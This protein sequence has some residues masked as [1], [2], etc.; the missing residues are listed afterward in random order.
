MTYLSADSR[1]H[2]SSYPGTIARSDST[3]RRAVKSEVR[4]R[5]IH[6]QR[7]RGEMGRRSAKQECRGRVDTYTDFRS[8]NVIRT[9]TP[10]R[11]NSVSHR[12]QHKMLNA[13]MT[14]H[15]LCLLQTPPTYL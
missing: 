11:R 12:T 6:G 9:S 4:R 2:L 5:G 15:E 1:R 7:G 10:V 3:L 14:R 8:G 13:S